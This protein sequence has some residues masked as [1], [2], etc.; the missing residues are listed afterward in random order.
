M[1]QIEI[2]ID[3]KNGNFFKSL[4][5][6]ISYNIQCVLP[7]HSLNEFKIMVHHKN[8]LINL[9]FDYEVLFIIISRVEWHRVSYFKRESLIKISQVV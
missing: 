5:S 2:L 8:G 7:A 6:D 9:L 4:S 1:G 3:K